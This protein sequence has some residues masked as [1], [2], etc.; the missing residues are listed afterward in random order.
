MFRR[1]IEEDLDNVCQLREIG[2]GHNPKVPT[3]RGE[4]GYH[5]ANHAGAVHWGFGGGHQKKRIH[6][7]AIIFQSTIRA[8]GTVIVDRGRLKALDDADIRKLASK[9]GDPDRVLSEAL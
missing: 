1:V 8:N 7:D 6:V 3:F 5:G 9:Y 4:R 2:L